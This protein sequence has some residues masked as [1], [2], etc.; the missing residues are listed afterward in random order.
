MAEYSDAWEWI[1]L[2]TGQQ[3]SELA[4]RVCHVLAK[5]GRGIHNAPITYQNADW[6]HRRLI[7]VTWRGEM[8][9]W[10]GYALTALWGHSADQMLRFGVAPC[11]PRHLKL[12]F[13][14]RHSREGGICDRLPDALGQLEFVGALP[15]SDLSGGKG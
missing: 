11:G 7:E 1:N 10:D 3:C 5:A 6:T 2:Q 8:N 9:N 13:W 4:K 12:R 15:G 14:Q